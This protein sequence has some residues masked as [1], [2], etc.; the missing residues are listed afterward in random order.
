M[1]E[2]LSAPEFPDEGLAAHDRAADLVGMPWP[3][4]LRR[5]Q[6]DCAFAIPGI[7]LSISLGRDD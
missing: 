5:L 7:D 1:T 3:E 4:Q 6:K 2:Q